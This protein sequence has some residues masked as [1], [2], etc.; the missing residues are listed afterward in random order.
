MRRGLSVSTMGVET[1]LLVSL[2]V[3]IL[4]ALVLGVSV[5]RAAKRRQ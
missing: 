2:P 5:A 3:G 1:R 4:A